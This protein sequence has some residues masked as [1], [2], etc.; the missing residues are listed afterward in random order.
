M[1]RKRQH[2]GSAWSKS[3]DAKFAKFRRSGMSAGDIAVALGRSRAAIYQHFSSQKLTRTR[4]RS[5]PR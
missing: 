4:R 1:P 5:Q 2:H 3:D